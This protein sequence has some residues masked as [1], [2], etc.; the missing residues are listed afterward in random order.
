VKGRF[1]RG[2]ACGFLLFHVSLPWGAHGEEA[3]P[4]HRQSR[5]EDALDLIAAP[6]QFK[7]EYRT[8]KVGAKTKYAEELRTLLRNQE[9][10]S[11]T[12]Y[13]LFE[14]VDRVRTQESVS[15]PNTRMSE[16]GV[17]IGATTSY[18]VAQGERLFL[19]DLLDH[20]GA[21][22]VVLR[23][24]E[25][26]LQYD[27]IQNLLRV[28]ESSEPL[29]LRTMESIISP[30]PVTEIARERWSSAR[31]SEREVEGGEICFVNQ[32]PNIVL[33][34]K[35]AKAAPHLPV[36]AWIRASDS[37]QMMLGAFLSYGDK[38]GVVVPKIVLSVRETPQQV[39]I[40][41]YAFQDYSLLTDS[42]AISLTV[43]TDVRVRSAVGGRTQTFDS[44]E[45]VPANWRAMLTVTK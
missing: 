28:T 12:F 9:G 37:E 21:M 43:R 6:A 11:G 3:T 1:V 19:Q 20:P 2:L 10:Q 13:A 32:D 27:R 24:P 34:V 38:E 15:D 25:V 44:L 26:T 42:D 18:Y 14:L 45:A 16:S 23:G 17:Y 31:L 30:L 39:R 33:S 4:V 40:D 5:L 36:G 22:P 8:T 35:C 29:D 41:E 7:L